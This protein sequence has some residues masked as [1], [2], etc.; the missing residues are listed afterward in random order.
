MTAQY[1]F[2]KVKK[3]VHVVFERPLGRSHDS[4]IDLFPQQDFTKVSKSWSYCVRPLK[5][6]GSV[7][8]LEVF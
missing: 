4:Q 5:L 1:K 3:F 6:F 2:V 7:K 8:C